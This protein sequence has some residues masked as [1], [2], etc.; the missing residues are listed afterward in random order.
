M[1]K[2]ALEAAVLDLRAS[3]FVERRRVKSLGH[4]LERRRRQLV[5]VDAQEAARHLE[6]LVDGGALALDGLAESLAVSAS[7]E[8]LSLRFLELVACVE[9]CLYVAALGADELV[10]GPCA[11]RWLAQRADG[12]G[13]VTISLLTKLLD[14]RAALG[15]E[16]IER[17]PVQLFAIG[18]DGRRSYGSSSVVVSRV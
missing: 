18:H 8:Q 1:T 9:Q 3:L 10:D 6:Q 5:T 7:G 12:G 14:Q 2:L 13:L 17:Q 4:P 16:A 11:D 15:D